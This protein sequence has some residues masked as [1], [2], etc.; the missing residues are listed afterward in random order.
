[1]HKH[2]ND[3]S[4]EKKWSNVKTLGKKLAKAKTSNYTSR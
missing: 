3:D 2:Q 4:E 1:M